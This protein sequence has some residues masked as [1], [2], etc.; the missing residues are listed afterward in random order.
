[1]SAALDKLLTQTARMVERLEKRR[2]EH[3]SAIEKIDAQFAS[4]A[5]TFGGSVPVARPAAR[6]LQPVP[7]PEPAAVPVSGAVIFGGVPDSSG[8]RRSGTDMNKFMGWSLDA[9]DW[10]DEAAPLF[11]ALKFSVIRDLLSAPVDL[12]RDAGMDAGLEDGLN[13]VLHRYGVE[14]G[15]GVPVP[16]VNDTGVAP[17]YNPELEREADEMEA[18]ELHG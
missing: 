7:A 11:H 1:M 5:K 15:G 14:L 17:V 8:V 16:V 13:E 3:I 2:G 12:M 4:I 10:P 9:V 18:M 6:R